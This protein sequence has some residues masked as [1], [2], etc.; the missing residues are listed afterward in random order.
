MEIHHDVFSNYARA[1]HWT[2]AS[3]PYPKKHLF[4]ICVPWPETIEYLLAVVDI[5]LK[6]SSGDEVI[7]YAL[8]L[9]TL[10]GS[11]GVYGSQART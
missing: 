11:G 1:E 2:V 7:L 10:S 8:P 9:V 6:G 5:G 4:W 3:R